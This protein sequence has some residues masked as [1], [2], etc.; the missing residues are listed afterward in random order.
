[1]GPQAENYR[2]NP[3]EILMVRWKVRTR[4]AG[5]V[6]DAPAQAAPAAAA[7]E[8]QVLTVPFKLH[9]VRG[10]EKA[11]EQTREEA[12]ELVDGVNAIW[13]QAGI[14]FELVGLTE[15]SIPLEQIRDTWPS[16]KGGRAAAES[17][18][19]R[20]FLPARARL[21]LPAILHRKRSHSI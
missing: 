9:L 1:M 8:R 18:R 3:Q 14:Q 15:P 4:L 6:P 16:G 17:S 11:A 20:A 21:R 19:P 13:A 12:K 7:P 5:E 10:S 2:L